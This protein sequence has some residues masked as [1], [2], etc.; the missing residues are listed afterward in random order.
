MSNLFIVL[1]ILAL[2]MLKLGTK[3]MYGNIQ[4][5]HI[6]THPAELETNK[7]FLKN[8]DIALNNLY[9]QIHNL[10]NITRVEIL[11]N[12]GTNFSGA[13]GDFGSDGNRYMAELLDRNRMRLQAQ[14]RNDIAKRRIP[15]Q[16]QQRSYLGGN[17][18]DCHFGE[19]QFAQDSDGKIL[20]IPSVPGNIHPY[21][22][23]PGYKDKYVTGGFF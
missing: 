20:G 16:A 10:D 5:S 21:H 15:Y 7:T 13:G 23:N 8:G 9:R 12:F 14:A 18:S 11:R 6:F 22:E 17:L 19:C 2:I 4:L 1:I 3:E